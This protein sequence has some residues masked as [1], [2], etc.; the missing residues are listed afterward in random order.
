MVVCKV[1]LYS[2]PKTLQRQ[3]IWGNSAQKKKRERYSFFHLPP[4]VDR[5]VEKNC[6]LFSAARDRRTE[7]LGLSFAFAINI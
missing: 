5:C 2:N 7:T 1:V 3:G 6:A 4:R